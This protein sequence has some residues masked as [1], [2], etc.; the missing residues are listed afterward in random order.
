VVEF[1]YM[2]K[3]VSEI[4]TAAAGLLLAGMLT[5]CDG[6]QSNGDIRK[7]TLDIS[8]WT[9]V[10]VSASDWRG[11]TYGNGKFVA[12]SFFSIAMYSTDGI[13]WTA[14]V[15]PGNMSA[16]GVTFGS[17]KFVAVGQGTGD[18]A[19]YSTDGINWT[20]MA[21]PISSGWHSVAFGNGRF[22]AVTWNIQVDIA[23]Y[24][25]VAEVALSFN[26]GGTVTWRK[27]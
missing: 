5:V 6:F 12:V 2:N 21:M 9:P 27:V 14:A 10:P 16:F 23:A 22:V 18:Q 24:I 19:A 7:K 8:N 26:A 17:G 3:K 20:L 25:D 1:W 15:L 4:V 11:A 13:N